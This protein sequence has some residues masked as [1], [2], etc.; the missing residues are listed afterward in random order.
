MRPSQ[1]RGSSVF[2]APV[3]SLLE[4][5]QINARDQGATLVEEE[6]WRPGLRR[7][8]ILKSTLEN[9]IPNG[10]VRNWEIFRADSIL[11][12]DMKLGPWR[13]V[14]PLPAT[15][16]RLGGG[17]DLR[18]DGPNDLSQDRPNSAQTRLNH[19]SVLPT[20]AL[21]SDVH[22]MFEAFRDELDEHNDRRERLIKASRD[23]T[24]LSKKIIFFL[25]RHLTS[26]S[27]TSPS[28]TD[29]GVRQRVRE[30]EPQF[31]AVKRLFATMQTDLQGG[32]FWRYAKSVS[33]GIQ[34]YIEA[35][36]FAHYLEHRGLIPYHVVVDSLKSDDGTPYFPLTV[37]D[38]LLGVS[39]LTGEIMRLSITSIGTQGTGLTNVLDIC[40]F[41]R[42]C[43]ADFEALTPFVRDLRKKQD[44]TAQSLQ[45]I[46]AAAY[47]LS[48]RGAEYANFELLRYHSSSYGEHQEPQYGTHEDG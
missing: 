19:I 4:Q 12:K 39:D 46:E 9:D 3:A 21:A 20:M 26:G 6:D 31:A 38:Y 34:E 11:L 45:K 43:C 5:A 16:E 1:I 29:S 24:N 37:E 22:G 41:V 32:L 7:T 17:G 44:V 28:S 33:G 48:L 30:A 36:S 18:S 8:G 40:A 35:L 15:F 13:A 2:D 25:H 10:E 14:K 47:S 27:A 42:S 23:V